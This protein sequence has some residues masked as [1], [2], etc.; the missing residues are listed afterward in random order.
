MPLKAE[1]SDV[2]GKRFHAFPLRGKAHAKILS[3][4]ARGIIGEHGDENLE[5]FG[6]DIVEEYVEQ[7][8]RVDTALRRAGYR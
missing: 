4:H 5:R 7:K 8:R 3:S 6:I 2:L 1:L